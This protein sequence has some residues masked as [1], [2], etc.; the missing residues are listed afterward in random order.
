MNGGKYLGFLKT[1]GAFCIACSTS[2]QFRTLPQKMY[3]IWKNRIKVT[4]EV[5]YTSQRGLGSSPHSRRSGT[6]DAYTGPEDA[7]ETIV[8]LNSLTN[9]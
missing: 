1:E 9:Y 4:S 3:T 2:L 7:P 6:E 8:L 5:F